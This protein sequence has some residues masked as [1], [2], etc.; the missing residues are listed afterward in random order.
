MSGAYLA[1]VKNAPLLLV[2]RNNT[3]KTIKY[4]EENLRPG[5]STIVYLL[6]ESDVV[7]E[8]V[9]LRLKRNLMSRDWPAKIVCNKSCYTK[10]SK[11]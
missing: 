2:N 4:I 7:P 1:K 10:G 9:R 11:S 5:N 8:T 6:G 3:E